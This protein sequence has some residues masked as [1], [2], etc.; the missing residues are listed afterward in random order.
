MASV[1]LYTGSEMAELHQASDA[2]AV[3]DEAPLIQEL[4]GVAHVINT[5][6]NTGEHS[7]VWQGPLDTQTITALE[8]AGYTVTE[9]EHAAI[10]NRIW[11]I[12]GF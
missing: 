11:D 10:P 5:A 12:T 4:M 9:R 7:A 1:S 6:A 8:G 3:A 2:K